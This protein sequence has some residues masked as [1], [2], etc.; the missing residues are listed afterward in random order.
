M[1]FF[2]FLSG[3]TY[4]QKISKTLSIERIRLKN[5]AFCDCVTYASLSSKDSVLIVNDGSAAGYFELGNYSKEAYGLIDSLAKEYSKISYPSKEGRSLIFMK[6]L[7]FY[8]SKQLQ[9]AIIKSDKYLL[10]NNKN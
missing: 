10:I 7:D 1:L 2:I 8:N 5:M 3:H 4:S 9:N 6:C